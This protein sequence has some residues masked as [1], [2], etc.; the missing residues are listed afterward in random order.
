MQ[1]ATKG[2]LSKAL[3]PPILDDRSRKKVR[4]K[5]DGQERD[6]VGIHHNLSFRDVLMSY[7]GEDLFSEDNRDSEGEIG[8]EDTN[9]EDSGS[10]PSEIER[11]RDADYTFRT[12]EGEPS[13]D[14]SDQR[15]HE[16]AR[17]WKRSVVGQYLIVR[18]WSPFY[19]KEMQDFTTIATWIRF[20]GMPLH[21][22]HNYARGF[23]L[24]DDRNRWNMRVYQGF[25]SIMGFMDM[26][27]R[28]ILNRIVNNQQQLTVRKKEMLHNRN[29][30]LLVFGC[31]CQGVKIGQA[32][33]GKENRV[34]T[35]E[36]N[37]LFQR[38]LVGE[39][40]MRESSPMDDSTGKRISPLVLKGN[41]ADL[42]D[43]RKNRD[44]L[45]QRS[46]LDPN[47]HIVATMV[48]NKVEKGLHTRKLM[49]WNAKV[50]GVAIHEKDFKTTN[51]KILTSLQ[52]MSITKW[53]RAKPIITTM[54]SNAMSSLL[55]DSGLNLALEDTVVEAIQQPVAIND[56]EKPSTIL[57][58]DTEENLRPT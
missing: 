56:L 23:F 44:I 28:S 43:A 32:N 9:M 19:H 25:V 14:I 17:K 45:P 33:G 35:Q 6:Q 22:Y 51:K 57:G 37:G 1:A 49:T 24:M 41:E 8:L 21:L 16:L 5:G 50:G 38:A 12:R 20:P 4:I 27:R 26:F 47:K 15:R 55:E 53:V 7:E 3:S 52:G 54:H 34:V 46:I 58:D 11:D 2:L 13:L 30:L 31:W 36:D 48:V 40:V 39:E 29:L 18:P 42:N 10:D